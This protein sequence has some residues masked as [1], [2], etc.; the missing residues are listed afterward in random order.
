MTTNGRR[1]DPARILG[2][3]ASPM[4]GARTWHIALAAASG[5]SWPGRINKKEW[6]QR[7]LKAASQA[8]RTAAN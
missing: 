7:C 8:G 3:D 4:V 6:E 5:H 2:L 1:Q